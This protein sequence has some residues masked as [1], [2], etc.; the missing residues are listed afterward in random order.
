[1]ANIMANIMTNIM[2][3][4]MANIMT[5]IMAQVRRLMAS[6]WETEPTSRPEVGD[7]VTR[8]AGYMSRWASLLH[9]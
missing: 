8:L 9:C 5:Y 6:C 1:M 3:N 4:I 2:T 7:L